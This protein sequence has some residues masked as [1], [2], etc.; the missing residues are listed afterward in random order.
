MARSGKLRGHDATLES[1]GS[2]SFIQWFFQPAM[3]FRM[4]LIAGV[5]ALW[6]YA[7]QR[8][9]S[10]GNRPE[11]RIAFSQIQV[12]PAPEYPIPP[13]LL[14]IVAEQSGMPHELSL[15][16]ETLTRDVADA[17]RRNPWVAKVV[18][19]RKSFP[20]TVTVELEYRRAVMM[21]QVPGGRI[22][23][24]LDGVI[25]PTSD[26]AASDVVGFPLIRNIESKPKLRPGETWD[27]PC[28]IAGARL[29][30]VLG[31]Q[32]KSLKL[33]AIQIAARSPDPNEIIL[34]LVGQ[35]GS[36]ILWGRAPGSN[37]PGELEA[38]QKVR[39]IEKYLADYGD[40]TKPSGPYE[41]DIRHWQEIS[42]R[43]LVNGT[44]QTKPGKTPKPQGK[45]PVDAAKVKLREAQNLKVE[46]RR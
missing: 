45:E 3:L 16:S 23:V 21:A 10:L 18:R 22:P 8:L 31:E 42:R 12:I 29:A 35:G 46:R 39:R 26:F 33:E 30:N 38:T 4:S 34:E 14:D 15:L 27:D 2:E 44:A 11:Y 17:F 5:I 43:P 9:P 40:Y 19:V 36:R 32:W 13:N 24:D 25:L 7:A 41:I 37:H 6:P 28:V 1:P 20:A